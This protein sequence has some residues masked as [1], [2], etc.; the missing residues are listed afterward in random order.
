MVD[1]KRMEEIAAEYGLNQEEASI[2]IDGLLHIVEKQ[3]HER[4]ALRR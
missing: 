1:R 3:E 2:A 4:A